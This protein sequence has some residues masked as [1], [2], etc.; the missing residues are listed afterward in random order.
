[1]YQALLLRQSE[2]IRIPGKRTVYRVM[3][4]IELIRRPKILRREQAAESTWR[5]APASDISKYKRTCISFQA[6]AGDD[7]FL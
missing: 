3:E 6:D 5:P 7:D 1:M 2:G 4:K